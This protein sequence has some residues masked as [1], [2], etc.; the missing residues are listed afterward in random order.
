MSKVSIKNVKPNGKFRS[1]KFVPQHPE[2][3]IGD[4]DNI[5]YRSSWEGRFCFYCDQNPNILRWASESIPI[6]YWN[7]IDKKE[8]TYYPDYYIKVKKVDGTEESWIVEVKP[9]AQYE[10]DK[11][12]QFKGNQTEKRINS[13]NA[14]METWIINRA[15]MDAAM[16]FA[17]FNGYKF[18]AVNEDFIFR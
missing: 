15:K 2:K 13:H 11:K 8:H 17:E 4:A 6:K 9:S 10:L 12:P 5:I 18:G 14:Q 1:G 16:K 7:P 3:Y